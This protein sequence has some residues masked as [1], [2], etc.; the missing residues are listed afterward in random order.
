MAV[1]WKNVEEQIEDNTHLNQDTPVALDDSGEVDATF[2]ESPSAGPKWESVVQDEPKPIKGWA[3]YHAHIEEAERQAQE[4]SNH[5]S[6][7]MEDL[8]DD[9]PIDFDAIED[10]F[11]N[12]EE[13]ERK[14]QEHTNSLPSAVGMVALRLAKKSGRDYQTPEQAT[15]WLIRDSGVSIDQ[16]NEYADP[17]TGDI[18]QFLKDELE[19]AIDAR[20]TLIHKRIEKAQNKKGSEGKPHKT[21]QASKQ[22]TRKAPRTPS[23][24][25]NWTSASDIR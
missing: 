12:I 3:P 22:I 7:E 4:N 6:S 16:L 13:S 5:D 10:E 2:S 1:D 11:N 21:A 25:K 23:K 20:D 24:R 18:P 14:W 17:A 19:L 15:R 8:E 9:E